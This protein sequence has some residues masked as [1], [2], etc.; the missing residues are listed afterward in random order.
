MT[1]NRPSKDYCNP[2]VFRILTVS[3]PVFTPKKVSLKSI[4]TATCEVLDIKRMDLLSPRKDGDLPMGRHIAFALARNYT[5]LSLKEIAHPFN[6]DHSTVIYGSRKCNE[7]KK[8]YID[9]GEKYNRI[10]Q[11]VLS[12]SRKAQ[13][14]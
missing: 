3:I 14:V 1:R 2:C 10:K 6:A 13:L 4:I 12:E 9:Y 8:L 7:Q 11:A 5:G